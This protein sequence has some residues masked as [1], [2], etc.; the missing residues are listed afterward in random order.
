MNKHNFTDMRIT[1]FEIKNRNQDTKHDQRP[2]H[3]NNEGDGGNK[4]QE[5]NRNNEK[6][7]DTKKI[8]QTTD[9]IN[10]P[11]QGIIKCGD[12]EKEDIPCPHHEGKHKHSKCFH[13]IC[14]FNKE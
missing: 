1:K 14:K 12:G 2:K 9:A 3:K 10:K 5:N 8:N 11:S 6:A 4:N 13:D 7:Q